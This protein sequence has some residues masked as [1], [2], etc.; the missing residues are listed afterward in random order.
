MTSSMLQG[1][2]GT[3]VII[4]S[5][6]SLQLLNAPKQ[7]R[8]QNYALPFIALVFALLSLVVLYA[9]KDL[10]EGVKNWLL[11]AAPVL[12]Q[13]DQVQWNYVIANTN[14]VMLF[15]A[16]KLV[17]RIV[18][19]LLF[20]GE[21][22]LGSTFVEKFYEY[23]D[24]EERWFVRDHL[25]QLR[26]FWRSLFWVSIAL[27]AA[28]VFAMA[29]VPAWQG[30]LAIVYP[31]L[32]TMVIGEFLYA[33]DGVTGDELKDRI[34]GEDDSANRVANYVALRE[35]FESE[36]ADRVIDGGVDLANPYWSNTY[37]TLDELLSS[38]SD[39]DQIYGDYFDRAKQAGESIEE[40]L[41]HASL[42]IYGGASTL[43]NTPFYNDL[44]HYLALPAYIRLLSGGKTLIVAGRDS[45]AEDLRTWFHQGLER[46]TGA[47]GLWRAEVLRES[48][49]DAL[50]V[51]IL[52]P[53]DLHNMELL[54]ANDEFFRDVE[55]VILV[56]PSR[57]LATSQ[58]GLGLVV[59]RLSRGEEPTYVGI[60]RNHDGLVDSLSHLLKVSITDVVATQQSLGSS[61][62]SVWSAEGPRLASQILPG[63]SR[64]LGLGTE[65]SA[66]ALK[67]HVSRVEWVGG[68]RFPVVDMSWI[69]GQY[70][71]KITSFAE[72]D[73]SQREMATALQARPNPL[74]LEQEKRR[75][76]VVEDE[77]WNVYE[78]LRLFASRST[79]TGFINLISENYLLR[80]YMVDNRELFSIDPKAIPSI[81]PDY[82]RSKR[83]TVLRLLVLLTEFGV[84]E[85]VLLRE[86]ELVGCVPVSNSYRAGSISPAVELLRGLSSNTWESRT[87]GSPGLRGCRT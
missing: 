58:L 48:A 65:I 2:L 84:P 61:S 74:A 39:I 31:A 18:S 12:E 56:E 59:S 40:N 29:E 35:V 26:A 57:L 51:G 5:L 45:A 86:L 23:V 8:H 49:I 24:Q 14:I 63:I 33:I 87:S 7:R 17:Y 79:E 62:E 37:L 42:G 27:T 64:Y 3:L 41:V 69:A 60:D 1:L 82:A 21:E 4:G 55:L 46:I 50:D 32:A 20:D 34:S 19:A 11:G 71:G 77:F 80:D 76:L 28:L 13:L 43:I 10:F 15:F 38:E 6:L 67:F 75:F 47:P 78:A 70:Y 73:P 36:F 25:N 44:T 85:S 30:F 72:M 83:N 66:T 52:S 22:F 68:D 54:R 9:A 16:V 53:A 81:V